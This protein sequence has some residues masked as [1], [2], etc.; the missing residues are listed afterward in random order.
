[1][2]DETGAVETRIMDAIAAATDLSALEDV[3]VAAL[4]KKGEVSALLKTLGG[5]DADDRQRLGPVF[6]QLK[7][8]VTEAVQ[9]RRATLE[10]EDMSRRLASETLDMT[11]PVDTDPQFEG[12]IHPVSQ[13][14]E[15]LSAIFASMGFDVAEGPDIESGFYNFTALNIPEAHPARQMHD[16]FYLTAEE[17]GEPLL[18]RTHTSPVQV[19]TMQAGDPPFRF[20]APG[21]TYR[22]DSDQT[23][24]PMFHQ[25]EGMVVDEATHMGHL[26]HT[27]EAF[28]TA[29]FEVDNVAIRFRP[30]YF[31]FTEP[32]ME[33]DMRCHRDGDKLVVGSGD[34]W[35]E[36]GGSGMVN[37]HV[38]THAGIDAEKYQGFAFGMGIDRLAMLKYGMPDLRAFFGA[39]LRWLKHYGFLPI[40][41]PGLAGGLS[42]KSLAA[43]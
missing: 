27:L 13:T 41:V 32:S 14:M 23:H 2:Q 22:C 43:K 9:S 1:M 16:T 20:I 7:I 30:S 24:T 5:M 34:D 38:L 29:F 35:M 37:P 3:R 33:V 4:G 11:L 39:D 36:I 40:D 21:R 8:R 28:L 18:L 17:D 19:R 42:N 12:R 10:A 26:K 31:P 6:N 25:M 15:E